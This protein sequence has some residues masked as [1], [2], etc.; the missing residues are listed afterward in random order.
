MDTLAHDWLFV[1][2]PGLTGREGM[3]E[4]LQGGAS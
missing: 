1:K 3:M 2:T 4:I